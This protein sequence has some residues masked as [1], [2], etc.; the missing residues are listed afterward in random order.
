M[1]T[2]MSSKITVDYVLS[3][4]DERQKNDI[5]PEPSSEDVLEFVN[6]LKTTYI[7]KKMSEADSEWLYKLSEAYYVLLR[8][9]SGVKIL[10]LG[11]EPQSISNPRT[12]K[13]DVIKQYYGGVLFYDNR[14]CS[15]DIRDGFLPNVDVLKYSCGCHEVCRCKFTNLPHSLLGDEVVIWNNSD[16]GTLLTR[17]NYEV[18][19]L[20]P[21]D[22]IFGHRYLDKSGSINYKKYCEEKELTP[23]YWFAIENSDVL[24]KDS[25]P[26]IPLLDDFVKNIRN[27]KSVT[28]YQKRL[29]LKKIDEISSIISPLKSG[30]MIHLIH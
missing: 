3:I 11:S 1:P 28:Y 17:K 22:A 8:D 4:L 26:G 10:W 15:N 18:Y 30:L 27:V 24:I 5:V 20:A 19:V 9:T 12:T 6:F 25:E 7:P 14:K 16:S 29:D 2:K 13:T 23:R 21:P